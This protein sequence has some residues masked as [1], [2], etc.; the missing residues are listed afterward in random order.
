[1]E[2]CAGGNA[3]SRATGYGSIDLTDLIKNK[4]LGGKRSSPQEQSELTKETKKGKNNVKVP[5][6][7]VYFAEWDILKWADD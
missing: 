3:S 5:T 4:K 7:S 2:E 1:M 6:V